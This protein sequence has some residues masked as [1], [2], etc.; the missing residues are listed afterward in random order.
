MSIPLNSCIILGGTGAVGKCLVKDALSSNAFTRVLSLGRRPIS[1]ENDS[2][3]T[4][5]AA[6]EQQS[7]DFEN[8]ETTFPQTNVPQVVFCALGTTRAAAGSAENFKKIDQQYVIDS[9]RYVHEKAPKDPVTGL[10]KVHFVYCSSGG[11]NPNSFFLYTKTKGETEKALAEI[12]FERVSI[13]QPSFLKTVEPRAGVR[14][15]EWVVGKLV[16]VL[17][18]ISEKNSTISVASVALAMRLAGT[19]ETADVQG[20]SPKSLGVNPK[21]KTKV[22]YFSNP[23]IHDI[24]NKYNTSSPKL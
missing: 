13:F 17:E 24:V 12:G 4:N 5:L 11:A 21:S 6:L 9:A 8:I 2:S 22:A 3:F 23:N 16:P 15:A 1:T 10:S 18:F 19:S 7:V 14:S 20:V